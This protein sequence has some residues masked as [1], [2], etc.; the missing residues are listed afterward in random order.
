MP[1]ELPPAPS[2]LRPGP[3]LATLLGIDRR[4]LA[5]FRIG[6]GLM[7]LLDLYGRA[8][9][10][11]MH[12]TGEGA[13]PLALARE[14]VQPDL[15][16]F[17]VF[18]LSDRV[19]VQAVLFVVFALLALAFLLGY[20]TRVV[21]VLVFVFLVSLMRRNHWNCHTGDAW[22][23]TLVAWS[24]FL[25]LGA[26]LSLDRL[27]ARRRGRGPAPAAP[28]VFSVAT[29]GLL[30]QVAI[31]YVSAGYLKSRYDVWTRGEAVW[32]F[33]HVIEYTRP[34]G[35][36]L[37]RFPEA[38]RFLTLST[39]ALE[40]LVPFLL[41]V[42]FATARIRTLL[43]VVYAAFHLTLQATIHI[44]IFQLLCIVALTP[45]LPGAFW[46]ELARCVPESVGARWR[47]VKE[48]LGAGGTAPAPGPGPGWLAARATGAFLALAMVLIVVSNVNTAFK[49]PYVRE[50]RGP[51][52]LPVW[53]D[54]YGRMFCVVQNWN[55]FT[56]IER[57]FFGWFLVLGQQE[58]GQH[59]D[60]LERRP[61]GVLRPPE[62]YARSFPNHNSRRY[63]REMARPERTDLQKTLCDYLAREWQ[64]E[65][66]TPL[67][68]IAIYHVGRIPGRHPESDQDQVK[69]ICSQWEAPHEPLRNAS[70]EVRQLWEERRERWR[71]FLASLP[72]TVPSAN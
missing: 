20:Q 57:A 3:S 71:S 24:L 61:A 42:P 66:R 44:G 1:S 70:I 59:V 19:E 35:A 32:I 67:T 5:A 27:R 8:K 34:F 10:L 45:F 12:Y 49:D 30:L 11:R 60:L 14:L 38:C 46:D 65:G 54:R 37:G 48:R 72:T 9:T 7:L 69:P 29:A 68:H 13:Y 21:G 17:H 40:M 51:L 50:D 55:M 53:L 22:L 23:S 64:R 33:T 56:D 41:F 63:W 36:W 16:L 47:A 25:P 39:L 58:D 26:H 62:H 2:P 43:V 4:S 15:A 6:L 52:P 18:L 28:T 31:F